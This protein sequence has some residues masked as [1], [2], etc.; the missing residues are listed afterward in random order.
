MNSIR[1]ILLNSVV[2]AGLIAFT[3]SALAEVAVIANPDSAIASAS[4]DDIKRLFLGKTK[5][6]SGSK[7][8]PVDQNDDSAA[9]EFFYQVVVGKTNAQLRAY[10]SKLI[11]TGKGKP[12]K[13]LDTDADVVA[14][15]AGDPSLVGY[16]DAA[17]VTGDVTVILVVQ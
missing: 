17:A 10:W 9:R 15:V 16:V 3:G 11:F 4:N 14:A 5:T 7:A 2:V 13:Q 8:T 1:K 12:P 6:V